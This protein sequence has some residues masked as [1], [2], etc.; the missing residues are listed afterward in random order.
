MSPDFT[1][2]QRQSAVGVIVTF[3]DSAVAL[4]KAFLPFLVVWLLNFD[5]SK[6]IMVT[7]AIVLFL[8]ATIVAA[9]L[10]YRNFT[11]FLDREQ[12]EFILTQGVLSK[13]RVV[14]QLG[15]IQKVDITQS[16]LQRL[17]GVYEVRIDTAGSNDEEIAI[18]AV[19]HAVAVS[20]R[21]ELL[22]GAASARLETEETT[23]SLSATGQ[24]FVRISLF[25]LIKMGLTSHYLRTFF[26]IL[27]FFFSTYENIRHFDDKITD[28]VD[29][30]QLES[31]VAE[32]SAI[33]IVLF[34][35]LL[36]VG[37]ILVVNVG[38]MVFRY[39]GYRITRQRD[40][41]LLSF[42]LV[43]TKNTLLKPQRVQFVSVIQNYLQRKLDLMEV[44]VRQATGGEAEDKKRAIE[45]PGCNDAEHRG[46]L[47]MLF[48]SVPQ[49]ELTVL[50][51]WRVLGF[52]LFLYLCIPLGIYAIVRNNVPELS[53]VDYFVP[54]Y[55]GLVIVLQYFR[56]RNSRLYISDRFVI[57]K[58]GAWDVTYD[59]LDTRKIQGIT[60]SQLFWHKSLNIGSITLHTAGGDLT[61]HLGQFDLL[62]DYAN[63]WL[64]AIERDDSNWM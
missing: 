2:P 33:Q 30:S 49:K 27:A 19:A 16:L 41:L 44:R 4:A 32:R 54:L 56:F 17:I 10:R 31:Y 13:T 5:R 45:I 36:I 3:A 15:K 48:G 59:Y 25:S 64:Y 37:V 55:A 18:K 22:E 61:F 58:H 12:S 7:A 9:W 1:K 57:R 20:L 28:D 46:I 62:H 53:S 11:F 29:T 24:P 52:A 26:V 39:F 47:E 42:G 51:N 60:A 50:P 40:A 23:E 63:R 6:S 38:R 34:A 35:F 14:I 8:V 43:S 21:K